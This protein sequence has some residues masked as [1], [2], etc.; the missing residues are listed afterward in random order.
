MKLLISTV[1]WTDTE[2][3]IMAPA[4]LKSMCVQKGIPTVAVDLNQ[5]SI[6]FI[7]KNFDSGEVKQLQQ[8]FYDTSRNVDIRLVSKTINYIV[9]KII[10]HNVTHVALSLLTYTSQVACEWI[11]FQI[12]RK[13]PQIKIIIGGAGVFNTL[14]SKTNFAKKLLQ[15]KQIDYYIKGDGDVTLP[16][17]VLEDTESI[18]VNQTEWK[19]VNDL[20]GLPFPDY[21][22]YDWSLYKNKSVGVVGSRGCVRH[23]TFCDIHEHWKRFQWRTGEDIFKE[24]IWHNKNSGVQ[25]FKFQDSLINGNIIEFRKLMK[26][27]AAHNDNNSDNQLKWSSFF[28]FR[29]ERQMSESDWIDISKSATVLT[30]GIEAINQN[31]RFHM[32][33]KFTNMDMHYCFNMCKK[34]NIK[35]QMLLIVGYVTDTEETNK[36]TMQ[37]FYENK[38]YVNNPIHSVSFGGTLGV[39]P[40]TEIYRKQEELGIELKNEQFDHDWT[41]HK[42]NNTPNVRLRWHNEQTEACVKSGFK[43]SSMTDNHLLMEKMMK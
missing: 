19:Q 27:L 17:L 38:H 26:L 22:D 6:N 10:E 28:I 25:R 9:D 11:C 43:V 12:R 29:P 37:W 4:L 18:G 3:P 5:V 16:D 33:K 8:F 35:V 34:Y 36:E 40:G 23:C 31:V 14:N 1:P 32:G 42:T 30:V 24:L 41:I 21:S 15:Q 39:L 13:A 2:S 20:N 7:K